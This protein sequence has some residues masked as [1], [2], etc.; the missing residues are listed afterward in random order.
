MPTKPQDMI[1]FK[2]ETKTMKRQ[3]REVTIRQVMNGFVV[4]VGCQTVV[5]ENST[6]MLQQLAAYIESP[7]D[8]EREFE[9]KYG[10]G[11][12]EGVGQVCDTENIKQ[13]ERPAMIRR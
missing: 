9:S 7:K 12:E 11:C 1:L 10:S 4:N 13:A 3:I 2:R 5:F 6:N 8:K